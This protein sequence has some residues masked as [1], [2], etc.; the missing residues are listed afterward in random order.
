M[1]GQSYH[2]RNQ[3]MISALAKM[4]DGTQVQPEQPKESSPILSSQEDDVMTTAASKDFGEIPEIL[5]EEIF[6]AVTSDR[7]STPELSLQ[8][9]DRRDLRSRT[10]AP[11]L[12]HLTQEPESEREIVATSD[13]TGQQRMVDFKSEYNNLVSPSTSTERDCWNLQAEVNRLQNIEQEVC[14]LQQ[15][16]HNLQGET[17]YLRYEAH[18]FATLYNEATQDKDDMEAQIDNLQKGLDACKDDLFRLQPVA[19]T[20]DTEILEDFES[21]VQHIRHWVEVEIDIFEKKYLHARNEE[22]FSAD[23][24]EDVARVLQRFP[25]AGEYLVRYMIHHYLQAHMLGEG[26][27]FLGLSELFICILQEVENSMAQLQPRRGM[28]S[29]SKS[30]YSKISTELTQYR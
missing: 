7:T 12:W 26:V 1:N 21:L 30:P 17:H 29:L 13:A 20:P 16:Y 5:L 4:D 25:Q 2:S 11:Q 14:Q 22:L 28:K 15:S 6:E 19:Q 18:K 23:G 3:E 24:N 27:Y 10:E 9:E 8:I